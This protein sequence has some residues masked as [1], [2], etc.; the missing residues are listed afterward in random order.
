MVSKFLLFTGKQFVRS[1]K[2]FVI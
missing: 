1:N 2:Y